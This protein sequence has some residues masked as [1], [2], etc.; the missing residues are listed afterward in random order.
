MVDKRSKTWRD[1]AGI[2]CFAGSIIFGVGGL[3][4]F[5]FDAVSIGGFARMAATSLVL[6]LVGA[7]FA[8]RSADLR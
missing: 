8:A 4:L 2:V 3:V 7:Y 1:V 5:V 6:C